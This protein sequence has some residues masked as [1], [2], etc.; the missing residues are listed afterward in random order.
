MKGYNLTAEE[1]LE[2]FGD[3]DPDQYDDEARERWGDTE[4]FRQSEQRVARYTDADWAEIKAE[5][6]AVT[7]RLAA[8][9]AAGD[10]ALDRGPDRDDV[11]RALLALPGI[12]PWTA[13]YIAL[14][15]L[16]HPDIHL[17]TDVGV[18]NALTALGRPDAEADVALTWAPWRSYALLHLWTSL[19]ESS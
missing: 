13:D 16:G 15:A 7:E 4:A 14:R 2:V 8:A 19:E 1:K 17:P 6:A 3:F 10:V 18:R 11:R 5:G 9:L 12:G